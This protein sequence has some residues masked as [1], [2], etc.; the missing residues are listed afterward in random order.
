[1]AAL[2]AVFFLYPAQALACGDQPDASTHEIFELMALGVVLY[3]IGLFVALWLA[4]GLR[5]RVTRFLVWTTTSA[6]G[7]VALL[8]GFNASNN[9][10]DQRDRLIA[11]ALLAIGTCLSGISILQLAN[12]LARIKTKRTPAADRY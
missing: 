2:A 9:V 7:A 10:S 1:M 12:K 5:Q 11:L 4:P 8:L 6:G 3:G